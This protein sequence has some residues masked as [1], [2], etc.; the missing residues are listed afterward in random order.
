MCSSRTRSSRR[1]APTRSPGSSSTTSPGTN[2]R[3]LTRNGYPSRRTVTIT[4]VDEKGHAVEGLSTT[5]LAVLEDGSARTPVSLEPDARPVTLA[6][7]VD[8]SEPLGTQF[9]LNFLD[10]LVAFLGRLP[11]GSGE[12]RA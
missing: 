2:S 8:S 1:S 12:A 10:A 7:V 3:V 5:D 9:R 4:V 11:E 6:L